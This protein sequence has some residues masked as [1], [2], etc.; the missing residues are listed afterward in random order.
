MIRALSL[1]DAPEE[2][3]SEVA[4]EVVQ[5]CSVGPKSKS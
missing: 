4:P 3:R 5:Q 2:N 1:E